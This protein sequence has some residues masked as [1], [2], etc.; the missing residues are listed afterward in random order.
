VHDRAALVLNGHDHDLERMRPH[1]GVV[2][3]VVGGG[4]RSLRDVNEDDPR[5]AFET[6]DE[7]GALRLELAPDEAQLALVAADDGAV[8]D[9][10]AVP[11]RG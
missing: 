1:D 4:G 3:E 9:R 6:D 11:C 10:A 2:E 5:L 8:L 7:Y